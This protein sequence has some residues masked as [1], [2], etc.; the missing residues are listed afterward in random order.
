MISQ[1]AHLILYVTM[2]IQVQVTAIANVNSRHHL[3][4]QET[5]HGALPLQAMNIIALGMVHT[6]DASQMR[7]DMTVYGSARPIAVLTL[8]VQVSDLTQT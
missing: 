5:D 2:S 6:I 3:S 4:A 7:W 8:H 1:D